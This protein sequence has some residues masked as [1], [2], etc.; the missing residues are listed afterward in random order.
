MNVVGMTKLVLDDTGRLVEF[1][2]VPPRAED[3]AAVT[4]AAPWPALFA[5][6]GL[7]MN[8][9]RE[10]PPQVVPRSFATERAAWEGPLAGV[11]GG[12][13]HV[14]AA[15][16]RGKA[17]SFKVTG[18]WEPIVPGTTPPV[19]RSSQFWP[20][21]ANAIGHDRHVLRRCCWR[22]ATFARAAAIGAAPGDSSASR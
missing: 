6:A 22:A 5:A 9:F 14:E 15:A 16:H 2:A 20:N 12:V 1:E 17:V 13:L 19:A 4:A 10:V 21:V 18:P 8:L 11:E 3:A 7:D